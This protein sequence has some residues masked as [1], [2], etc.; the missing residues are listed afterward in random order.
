[1]KKFQGQTR[2]AF[3]SGPLF[4][5]VIDH[6]NFSDLEERREIL[7]TVLPGECYKQLLQAGFPHSIHKAQLNARCSHQYQAVLAQCK[8]IGNIALWQFKKS[9]SSSV[10]KSCYI[11]AF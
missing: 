2:S 1:M 11:V 7:L 5:C 9:L 8:Q 3:T 4:L 6:Y 10:L